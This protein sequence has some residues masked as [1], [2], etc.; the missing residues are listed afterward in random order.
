VCLSVRHTP[1]DYCVETTRRIELELVFDIDVSCPRQYTVLYIQV[2][3]KYTNFLE[4]YH[5]L[6]LK[7]ELV[8][9]TTVYEPAHSLYLL[10][11]QGSFL[12]RGNPPQ[13]ITLSPQTA[14]ILCSRSFFDPFGRNS[15]LQIYHR[16]FLL[17]DNKYRKSFLIKQS[18]DA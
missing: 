8:D 5:I 18:K 14:S 2:S 7:N 9:H 4:P 17:M 12:E 10:L 6:D 11:F 13:K 1:V 3:P 16:N 15:E